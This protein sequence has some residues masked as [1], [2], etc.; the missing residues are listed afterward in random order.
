[1]AIALAALGAI[2]M[3][4]NPWFTAVD[5]EVVILDVAARP[6]LQT[7]KLFLGGSGQHEH[8]PLSDLV[9]HGWLWLTNG[10][11]HL[12][13]L[14]SVVFYLL[15]IWFL[16]QAAR[17]IGGDRAGYCTLTLLLL[18]PNG[19]HYGRVAG[20]YAFTFMLV[21][22][23]TL[24]DVKYLEDQSLVTVLGICA[25]ALIYTNY[26]GWAV[27]GCLGFDFLLRFWRDIRKWLLLISTGA[28]LVL[29]CAPIVPA[30]LQ[31]LHR[32]AKPAPSISAL[33]IGVYN[34][35]CLFVGESV[36]PWFWALGIAAGLAIAWAMVL[37]LVTQAR[38]LADSCF[39]SPRF[40]SS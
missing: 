2:L 10:N 37:A 27:L 11:L 18:W 19:F 33:A 26:F 28:L 17:R 8:P 29:A 13:R 22:L 39:I 7:I 34:L 30:F 6:A 38:R 14:P 32:G 25:L 40:F 35:Y 36:A 21:S 3:V 9:L 24:T 5:D 31:E 15:G 1:M 12:L 16:V 23:L 4:T 20:W